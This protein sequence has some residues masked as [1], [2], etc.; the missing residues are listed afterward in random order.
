MLRKKGCPLLLVLALL[1]SGCAVSSGPALAPAP[2]EK[3]RLV[4]YTSHKEQVYGPIV[5]EFQERTG[6]WVEV[7]TG[8]TSDLLELLSAQADTPVCDVMF[9]GGAESLVAA[10]EVFE[11]YLSAGS[12][13]WKEGAKPEGD[14]WTP[15]ST[16]PIV[17]IYNTKL[18]PKGALT[19]W[20]DLLDEKWR[21]NIAFADPG[22]SGSSYTAL[23]TMLD[24]LPGEEDELLRRFA[25]NLDGRLLSDSGD[26]A[27]GVAAGRFHIGITLEETALKW[28]NQR[29]SLALVYPGEGTSAVPDGGALVR[30]APHRENAVRFLDFVQGRDVQELVVRELSRRSVR[31][32]VAEPADLPPEAELKVIDYDIARMAGRKAE[33]LLRWAGLYQ[34][35]TP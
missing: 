27:G 3:E 31:T 21:G 16:L 6:I 17:L 9:G 22:V 7:V 34:E 2:P 12:S 35:V 24:R 5:K 13:M 18:V 30:G 26:V 4:V 29:A 33:V 10:S 1:C 25:A 32:D 11:P 19:G 20:A 8:G 15:F 23:I 14:L 28:A